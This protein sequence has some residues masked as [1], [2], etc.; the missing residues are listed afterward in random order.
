M[1]CYCWPQSHQKG[2]IFNKTRIGTRN[3]L[4]SSFHLK[5]L[6]WSF[7]PKTSGLHMYFLQRKLCN[8]FLHSFHKSVIRRIWYTLYLLWVYRFR[9]DV[10]FPGVYTWYLYL[11]TW[12]SYNL[13]TLL[14]C[15]LSEHWLHLN[16]QF[17]SLLR[18]S[19]HLK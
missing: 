19:L 3:H 16:V 4:L 17:R 14:M 15:I 11:Y 1:S 8:A 12:I 18:E 10:C 9:I 13:L 7:L 6:S 2:D 5:H